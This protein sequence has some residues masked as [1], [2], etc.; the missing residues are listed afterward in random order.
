MPEIT[1]HAL[2]AELPANAIQ[3]IVDNPNTELVKSDSVMFFRPSGQ[4]S[5]GDQP[6]EGNIEQLSAQVGK[7]PSG[8]PVIAILDGMPLPNHQLLSDRIIL[9][10]PD[11]WNSDYPVSE[12][13]HGTMM[14]S[15]VIHGDLNAS[16]RVPLRT[17][18]YMRPIMRPNPPWVRQ[19]REVIPEDVLIVDLIHRAVKRIFEGENGQPPVAPSVKLI[20]LSVG[21]PSRPFPKP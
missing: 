3:N 7:L 12:R 4:V 1:Y 13:T 5:A 15:L 19:R 20:N 14:A 6:T 9:D 16:S 2:L 11:G 17:P 21:D 8:N 10:D 18:L